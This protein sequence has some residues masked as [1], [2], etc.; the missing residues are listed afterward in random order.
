MIFE[1]I[2]HNVS[3]YCITSCTDN[4]SI[5][6]SLR[7]STKRAWTIFVDFSIAH[8]VYMWATH[9]ILRCMSERG[10]NVHAAFSSFCS[11][12]VFHRSWCIHTSESR[13]L[14]I[15]VRTSTKRACS[16]MVIITSI[17]PSLMAY[18]DYR[19]NVYSSLSSLFRRFFS[20][21]HDVYTRSLKCIFINIVIISSIFYHRSR[22]IY[23]VDFFHRSGCIH[24]RKSRNS[25]IT[26]R[27]STKRVCSILV[28]IT[29]IFSPLM[30]YTHD[31]QNVNSSISSLFCRF[32]PSL[33]MWFF[34]SLTTYAHKRVTQFNDHSQNVD[35]ACMQ[36]YGN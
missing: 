9:A 10:Q 28:I 12:L 16:I 31:R 15:T 30:A 26:V 35:K 34:S 18:T 21:A 32:F 13:N 22:W 24:T 4:R 8:Y 36:H 25:T 17:F 14:T 6:I 19:S 3:I 33:R 20:I 11:S 1:S 5:V 29:S 7:T 2:V 27:T 23:I